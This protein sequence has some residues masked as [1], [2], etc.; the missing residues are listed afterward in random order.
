M[1]LAWSSKFR[2]KSLRLRLESVIKSE[3]RLFNFKKVFRFLTFLTKSLESWDS[4]IC[5]E[6]KFLRFFSVHKLEVYA[7]GVI[8][9]RFKF[10]QGISFF[11]ASKN[12]GFLIVG[13]VA[14][15]WYFSV[16]IFTVMESV[17][18]VFCIINPDFAYFLFLF[19]MNGFGLC[20]ISLDT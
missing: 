18:V 7:W 20:Y 3:Y 11:F 1:P 6:F 2:S 4:S 5:Y 16:K 14:I 15:A 19:G 9:C 8:D 10:S 13:L 17:V 12:V